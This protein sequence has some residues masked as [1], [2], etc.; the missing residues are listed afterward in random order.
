MKYFYKHIC[1]FLLLFCTNNL[2]ASHAGG[3]DISYE[4]ISQ[5]STFDLYKIKISFVKRNGPMPHNGY[6]AFNNGL[7][8]KILQKTRKITNLVEWIEKKEKYKK[9]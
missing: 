2:V 9:L 4:C 1:F 5:Q 6:R 3:M 7:L 8:K